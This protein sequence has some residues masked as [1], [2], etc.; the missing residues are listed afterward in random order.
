MDYGIEIKSLVKIIDKKTVID[1][2]NITV[3]KGSIHGLI[4]S[5]GAGKTITLK[6]LSGLLAATSGTIRINDINIEHSEEKYKK[7][8]GYVPENPTL[9]GA[10]K[11]RENIEFVVSLYPKNHD[12]VETS[13]EHY[14]DLFNLRE[15]EDEYARNLSGG[16]TQRA[17]LAA[18]MAHDPEIML[19]DE[20][21]HTLDPRSQLIFRTLLNE[22]RDEGKTILLATHLLNL[23]ESICDSVT[24]LSKGKTLYD[25]E[26]EEI[27]KA[28]SGESLEDIYLKLSQNEGST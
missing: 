7:D 16:E 28:F 17:F 18:V 21:F 13:I 23:A 3:P 5:N 22:K 26:I 14:L 2:L 11:V 1:D 10:L 8:M 24:L 15:I 12:S 4:G 6:I 25:G 19:L 27:K 9:Y 20:P